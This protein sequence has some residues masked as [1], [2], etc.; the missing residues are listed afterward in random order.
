MVP[1]TKL[2][3]VTHVS[4]ALGTIKAIKEI[5]VRLHNH[6]FDRIDG[7]ESIGD[8]RDRYQL[9]SRVQQSVVLVEYQ[10]ARII[11]RD[12]S[13]PRAFF[14][15]Q[16]LPGNNVGVMFHGG[17]DDLVTFANELATVTMHHEIDAFSRASNEDAFTRLTR[18]DKP[19]D[20]FSCAL[21]SSGRS[22]T[23]IVDASMNV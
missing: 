6:L 17:N 16:H 3:A 2:V 21:V 12:H 19:F 22:L 8:V 9:R 5:F 4:T 15:T 10:L 20:L 23:Q 11:H 13:Q 18:I 1:R 7:A 14:F